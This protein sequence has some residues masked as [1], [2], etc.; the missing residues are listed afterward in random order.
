MIIMDFVIA[1]VKVLWPRFVLNTDLCR[2]MSFYLG[3]IAIEAFARLTVCKR[4]GKAVREKES[5]YGLNTGFYKGMYDEMDI[6]DQINLFLKMFP[7]LQSDVLDYVRKIVY[8]KYSEQC[9][10]EKDDIETADLCAPR[11]DG[12]V[13]NKRPDKES[14]TYLAFPGN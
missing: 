8:K 12:W 3:G 6:I 2:I 1:E 7:D 14:Q 10:L 5:E 9:L 11:A 4:I 13:E